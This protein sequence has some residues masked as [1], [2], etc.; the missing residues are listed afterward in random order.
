[1]DR[2][3]A[4]R[5]FLADRMPNATLSWIHHLLRLYRR[6]RPVSRSA[7]FVEPACPGEAREARSQAEDHSS[8]KRNCTMYTRREAAATKRLPKKSKAS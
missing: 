6:H 1:M 8:S 7:P 5:L 4:L 3:A 2:L